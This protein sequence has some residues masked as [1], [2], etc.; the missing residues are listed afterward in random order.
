MKRT[1]E[2]AKGLL[3]AKVA[4][5]AMEKA[6][7]KKT[8]ESLHRLAA[9]G[10][11]DY[12]NI[13]DALKKAKTAK[14]KLPFDD[15]AKLLVPYVEDH[16]EELEGDGTGG[17]FTDSQILDIA[18][19]VAEKHASHIKE[20]TGMDSRTQNLQEGGVKA[21]MEDWIESLPKTLIAELKSKYGKALKDFSVG[22][23][24]YE[25]TVSLRRNIKELLVKNKVKPLL[26]DKTHNEGTLA[27]LISF[28]SFHGDMNEQAYSSYQE[29][30][31]EGVGAYTL[32]RT[33]VEKNEGEDGTQTITHY[34]VML[35][36]KKVGK[37]SRDDYFGQ[38]EG[39]LHGK[40]IPQTA[41]G[42]DIQAW[43]H[44]FLKSKKG[45]KFA[46]Q[47]EEMEDAVFEEGLKSKQK[48]VETLVSKA[49]FDLNKKPR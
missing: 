16:V 10:N 33:K 19:E 25:D 34:D 44:K 41:I 20:E 9:K 21:S 12:Q 24:S 6:A 49:K 48:L 43:L 3:E 38:V 29:E 14:G 28:H 27:V 15:A 4:G 26:G 1:K 13:V 7:V 18:Y 46:M 30:I 42:S 37:L 36:G 23:T 35:G 8:M 5:A 39:E 47:A 45:A 31:L 40:P 2:T 11:T 32:K 22:D 17:L